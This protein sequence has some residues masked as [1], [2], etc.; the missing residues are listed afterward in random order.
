MDKKTKSFTVSQL[1]EGLEQI[2]K[3]EGDREI[4]IASDEEG[5]SFGTI[6]VTSF[7]FDEDDKCLIIYPETQFI[8][9]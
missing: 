4:V 1:I 2:L 8:D 9:F 5:N 3:D 7:G 6:G